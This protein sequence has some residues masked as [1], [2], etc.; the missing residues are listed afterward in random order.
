[1]LRLLLTVLIVIVVVAAAKRLLSAGSRKAA[2]SSPARLVQCHHCGIYVTEDAALSDHD[3]YF[4]S[5]QHK[6]RSAGQ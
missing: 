5:R 3:R 2:G 4:C 1:M 6:N